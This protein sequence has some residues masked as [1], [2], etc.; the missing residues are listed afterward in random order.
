MDYLLDVFLF[1]QDLVACCDH[2]HLADLGKLAL[3]VLLQVSLELF[4]DLLIICEINLLYASQNKQGLISHMRMQFLSPLKSPRLENWFIGPSIIGNSRRPKYRKLGRN[5]TI[6]RFQYQL[7]LTLAKHCQIRQL[8]LD[9]LPISL[10]HLSSR[11]EP[12]CPCIFIY[13]YF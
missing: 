3:N 4:H 5:G 13:S 10:K 12:Q 1:A 2:R 8:F 9:I 6:N 7:S 11:Y